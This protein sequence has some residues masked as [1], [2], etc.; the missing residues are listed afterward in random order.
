MGWR[1]ALPPASR[2]KSDEPVERWLK[3]ISYAEILVL[4]PF[5]HQL[6]HEHSV[7]VR[8]GLYRLDT[9]GHDRHA[10][11]NHLHLPLMMRHSVD[12]GQVRRADYLQVTAAIAL[13]ILIRRKQLLEQQLGALMRKPPIASTRTAI[14]GLVGEGPVRGPTEQADDQ[15]DKKELE[16]DD[17]KN[18]ELTRR[19]PWAPR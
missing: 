8:N 18:H 16:G 9:Q 7:A 13:L 1:D 19:R 4:V 5:D 3:A 10:V 12:P 14:P 2:T 17:R 6:V 15:E 11:L